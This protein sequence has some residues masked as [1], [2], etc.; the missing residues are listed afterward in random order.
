MPR[1]RRASRRA[2]A[3]VAIRAAAVALGLPFAAEGAT[4]QTPA[5]PPSPFR[6][7]VAINAM[8][9]PFG[10]FSGEYEVALRSPGFAF[11]VGGS[12]FSNDGDRLSQ[13]EAKALYYPGEQ[14]FR[15]FSVG[16]TAGV[17]GERDETP[18]C[19]FLSCSNVRVP[20]SQSSPTLGVLVNYDWLLGRARR[21]RVG[22]GIGAK[23]TLRDVRDG[24][25]LEQV[26]PDGRFVIGVTF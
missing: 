12:Y 21:F 4:A 24:D 14:P 3:T 7:S 22:T 6:Q 19:G 8:G 18:D 23:R 13:I 5:P 17:I 15:G 25:V 11:G 1:L 26:Y 2:T 9:L 10:L 20:R 16:L